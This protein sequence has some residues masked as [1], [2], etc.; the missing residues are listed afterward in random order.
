[1]AA[2]ICETCKNKG[3]RCYCPPNSTC[4]GYEPKVITHFEEIKTMDIDELSKWIDENGQF[5][6]SPWMKWWNSTYC[7]NCESVMA[8]VPYLNRKRECA[9]CELN[10][11]CK[12]FPEMDRVPSCKDI[13]KIW[14]ESEVEE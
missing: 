14:L 3:K 5:D 1:M 7:H 8:F 12:F 13:V 6:G 4:S 9:W 11:K 10:G 2:Q